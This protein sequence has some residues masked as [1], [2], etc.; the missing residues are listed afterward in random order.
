MELGLPWNKPGGLFQLS[1]ATLIWGMGRC[2]PPANSSK[3][4]HLASQRMGERKNNI[5]PLSGQK[6]SLKRPS[7]SLFKKYIRIYIHVQR[8]KIIFDTWKV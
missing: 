6:Q 8:R 7:I 5:P 3:V 4:A 2:I 1:N